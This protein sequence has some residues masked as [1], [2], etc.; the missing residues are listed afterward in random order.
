MPTCPL[1]RKDLAELVPQCPRCKAD[2]SLLKDYVQEQQ[3]G[4][5]RA[6]ALARAGE[7]GEAVWA[8]LEVL[9][10]D[11]D[12]PAARRQVSRVAAA[13]RQFDGVARRRWLARRRQQ[14]RFGQAAAWYSRPWVPVAVGLVRGDL[15]REREHRAFDEL[16]Q[17]LVHLRLGSEV[18]V[19]RGFR[20]AEPFGKRGGSD[21][22]PP[23]RLEHLRKRFQDLEPAFAFGA[24]HYV[25]I[26][27]G[28]SVTEEMRMST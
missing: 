3:D 25:R 12:N 26:L 24:G 28:S 19:E 13:V 17:P 22:L 6:D 7:L 16:D 15:V 21:L 14:A 9:E 4:L 27:R 8:Y 23:R 2:L 1:C 10:V 18:A 5:A 20:D 11:P